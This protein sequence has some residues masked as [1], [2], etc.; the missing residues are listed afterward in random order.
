MV[1]R[2]AT[3]ADLPSLVRL[4]S[5]VQEMH[6]HHAPA[7]IKMPSADPGCAEL[8]RKMLTDPAACIIVAEEGQSVIGNFFAKEVKQEESWIRPELR[9][10]MLEH[11][12]VDPAV[13]R[14][15]I[16]R[17]LIEQFF[18]EAK[19]RG[20]GQVG[21]CCWSF[22]EAANRFFRRHG[23]AELHVRMERNL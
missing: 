13:R 23:F 9:T 17:R 20:I 22:N 2:P 18:D 19:T 6:A 4:A 7:H 15:G 21:L 5:I 8:L 16:G 14:K 3:E 12:V 1:L 10:F 11:I